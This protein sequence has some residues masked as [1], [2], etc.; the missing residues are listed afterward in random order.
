MPYGVQQPPKLKHSLLGCKFM[1][2][3]LFV[4]SWIT[5]RVSEVLQSA[6][7]LHAYTSGYQSVAR[8]HS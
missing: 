2:G 8:A 4:G 3:L 1:D 7:R 6:P 5:R